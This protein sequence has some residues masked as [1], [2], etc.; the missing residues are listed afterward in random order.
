MTPLAPA[1]IPA[2]AAQPRWLWHLPRIAPVLALVATAILLWYL[3]RNEIEEQ[4]AT[5]ISDVLWV[6]QNI[7]FQM[8]RNVEQLGQL[9]QDAIGGTLDATT[10]EARTAALMRNSQGIQRVM[11]I[12]ATGRPIRTSPPLPEAATRVAGLADAIAIATRLARPTYGPVRG[13]GND[14]EFAVVVPLFSR[15]NYAGTM[16]GVYS[17]RTLLAETVPWWFAQKYRLNVTDTNGS[18]L[19]SRSSVGAVSTTLS[20][21]IPFDPPGNGL[22]IEVTSHRL[23]T[24][25]LPTLLVVTIVALLIAV[26]FS[27]SSLR[28]HVQGRYAAEAAL[29]EEHAFRKAME[30]SLLTGLRARD[31][32]GRI[33]YVNPAFCRMVGWTAQELT[34]LMPPMPYWI[35]EQYEQTRAVHDLVLAGRAPPEGVEVRLQRR[36]GERFDAL[37]FEAPLID[38]QGKQRGWM[39]SVLDITERKRAQDFERQQHEKLQAT[40]RLVTMGELA[41]TL[42]HELNQPLSAIASYNTGCI[43]KLE[44]GAFTREQLLPILRK[45]GQQAQ[46]AGQIIRRVHEFVRRSEPNRVPSAIN[47]ILDDS[48]ALLEA[49]AMKRRARLDVTCAADLPDVLADRVMIEQ[50]VLN[51]ARNGLDAMTDTPSDQRRLAIA[52]RLHDEGMICVSIADRGC[53]I[54]KDTEEKLFSPFFTTK[55]EGMG[56][57][58]NICRSIIELHGGRLWFEANPGGGTIF[59]FTLPPASAEQETA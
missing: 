14:A 37:I 59:S 19:G 47:A 38:A 5:L 48:V 40:A 11:L 10:H 7:R 16:V 52:T 54:A 43:N 1:T 2:A 15:Q 8:E 42:A 29:R 28:R 46:R 17:L 25:I 45:M 23:E 18:I 31:L 57:G 51:L 32:D 58:L 13:G 3:H 6:E 20:Y 39:G 30:D 50:V 44:S 12:D 55:A 36:N 34:G 9:G 49:T 53:G 24:R 33:I 41:S 21:Q 26:V 35:P 27:L 56:M 22:T 4:R